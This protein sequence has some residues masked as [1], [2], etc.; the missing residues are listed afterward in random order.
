MVRRELLNRV[1][2]LVS[3]ARGFYRVRVQ[4]LKLAVAVE[5]SAI[6]FVLFVFEL[7]VVETKVGAY[8]G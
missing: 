5:T 8:V 4:K 2:G 6:A 3:I 1:A 7:T